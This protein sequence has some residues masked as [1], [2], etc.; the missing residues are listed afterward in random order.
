M[1]EQ[2][3]VP[4]VAERKVTYQQEEDRE[5]EHKIEQLDVKRKIL[6]L[7][8]RAASYHGDE[9]HEMSTGRWEEDREGHEEYP[10][11]KVEDTD[12]GELHVSRNVVLDTSDEN[13]D[14]YAN[15]RV[16]IAI[17]EF[18][19]IL[20]SYNEHQE[21]SVNVIKME[22]DEEIADGMPFFMNDDGD[23]DALVCSSYYN[24]ISLRVCDEAVRALDC[25]YPEVFAEV[26]HTSFLSCLLFFRRATE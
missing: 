25:S 14:G 4:T 9:G 11:L 3:L 1:G 8:E 18:P 22:E 12:D 13:E 23:D 2:L 7:G 10:V 20:E 24:E 16:G 15:M 19:S 26:R 17:V 5:F 21:C 6:T